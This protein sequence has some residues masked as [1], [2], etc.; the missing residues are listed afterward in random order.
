MEII[1]ADLRY[2]LNK[3]DKRPS[4]L[5]KEEIFGNKS[6]KLLKSVDCIQRS[7]GRILQKYDWEM[8]WNLIDD[9]EEWCAMIFKEFIDDKLIDIFLLNNN[10]SLR[11]NFEVINYDWHSSSHWFINMTSFRS[12]SVLDESR[13]GEVPDGDLSHTSV[14]T[15]TI[16]RP[17]L[18]ASV[19]VGVSVLKRETSTSYGIVWS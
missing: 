11:L 12:W 9:W 5:I 8:E 4:T 1:I 13:Y 3:A 18:P 17:T 14:T 10:E 2:I 15:S 7:M 16:T 6:W 19:V